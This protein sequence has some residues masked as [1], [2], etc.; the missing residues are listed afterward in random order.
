MP[1]IHPKGIDSYKIFDNAPKFQYQHC[2]N[3]Y[4]FILLYLGKFSNSHMT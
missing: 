3:M 2:I 1:P 4:K